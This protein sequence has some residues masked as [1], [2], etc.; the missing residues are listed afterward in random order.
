MVS[1]VLKLFLNPVRSSIKHAKILKTQDRTTD[2]LPKSVI[3]KQFWDKI[4]LWTSDV[5]AVAQ[6]REYPLFTTVPSIANRVLL[7]ENCELFAMASS[8]KPSMNWQA[9]DLYGEWKRFKQHCQFTF[10]GPLS[11][12]TEKEKVNYL[13]TYIGDKGR[14]IYLTFQWG[15][16]ERPD[17]TEVSER[18]TLS[19]V[20]QKYETY[21]QPKKN[22]IRATVNFHRRKQLE[23]RSSTILW[24]IW[25][26]L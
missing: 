19:G 25:N 6:H 2:L 21:V 12:K 4:W 22:E 9:K 17:G 7:S 5:V 13:M 3:W 15:T 24:Q 14:E 10:G 26:Y 11:N 20:Y 1:G 23:E 18:D 8:D 16:A